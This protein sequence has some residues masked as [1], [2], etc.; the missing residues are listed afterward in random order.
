MSSIAGNSARLKASKI[1]CLP[2][3]KRL[4]SKIANG[5]LDRREQVGKLRTGDKAHGDA[6][7]NLL[8]HAFVQRIEKRAAGIGVGRRF[9][10][11]PQSAA[12]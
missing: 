11:R 5:L 12:K 1:R 10:C 2:G 7:Q 6:A 3:R 9:D 4:L 8:F